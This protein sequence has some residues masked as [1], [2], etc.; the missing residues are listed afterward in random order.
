ML[1]S[2]RKVKR[3]AFW[4][5][6]ICLSFISCTIEP[7]EITDTNL[8]RRMAVHCLFS[9]NERMHFS[10]TRSTV[11]ID[12]ET[13]STDHLTGATARLYADGVLVGTFSEEPIEEVGS[14]SVY[15]IDY[16]PQE[17]VIYRIEVDH[18]NYPSIYG[19]SLIP[20]SV[21][22]IVSID[23]SVVHVLPG[24]NGDLNITV[25]LRVVDNSEINYSEIL[26]TNSSLSLGVF[27]SSSLQ[28]NYLVTP[29]DFRKQNSH[30]FNDDFF[31]DTY[32]DI[33]LRDIIVGYNVDLEN[34]D[35][36]LIIS[37]NITKEHFDYRR[38]TRLQS[39]NYKDPF[40]EPV[41]I[42]SNIQGGHG[43]FAGFNQTI[44]YLDIEN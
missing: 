11:N 37:K 43:I 8:D 12:G 1:V 17:G 28:P 5:G 26:L 27:K 10:L 13:G 36:L 39:Q 42:I 20:P 7:I 33:S 16:F 38:T 23:Y 22:N 15:R 25:Q 34:Y 29:L 18:Q 24:E 2:I 30:F 6:L 3:R 40:A 32:I 4:I 9:T 41:T 31:R 21:D 14:D 44:Y 35:D 19:E